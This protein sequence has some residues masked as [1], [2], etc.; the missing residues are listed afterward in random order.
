[1]IHTPPVPKEFTPG[2]SLT[3]PPTI[4]VVLDR[5]NPIARKLKIAWL[6]KTP[7]VEYTRNGSPTKEGS[8]ELGPYYSD[9]DGNG[10]GYTFDANFIE[11]LT[12]SA[13]VICKARYD[14][15][16]QSSNTM[17]GQG[18]NGEAEAANFT[19]LFSLTSSRAI[20]MFWENHG[21]LS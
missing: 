20:R 1:M 16:S 13:S 15:T 3:N 21:K 8:P 7:K 11:A 6:G 12:G 14:N 5:S 17:F 4:P 10:D 18:G 19:F 9:F 2:F